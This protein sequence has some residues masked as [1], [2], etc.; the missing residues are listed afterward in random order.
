MYLCLFIYYYKS[1]KSF[2]NSY[3]LAIPHALRR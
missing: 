1:V 3:L 2:D